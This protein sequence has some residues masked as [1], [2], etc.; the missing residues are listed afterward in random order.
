MIRLLDCNVL[1]YKTGDGRRRGKIR[2]ARDATLRDAREI[3]CSVRW[4]PIDRS[5][6]PRSSGARWA[7]NCRVASRR[8]ALDR[9]AAWHSLIVVGCGA[10]LDAWPRRLGKGSHT[11]LRSLSNWCSLHWR[12][13]TRRRI[14]D[15][16]SSGIP[17]KSSNK[18]MLHC[19]VWTH[20][21]LWIPA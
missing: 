16:S 18:F 4:G 1:T 2:L 5:L 15:G 6:D 21:A 7:T 9:G 12:C 3:T 13:S 8:A 11:G 10:I 17:A 14:A 19:L 20:A